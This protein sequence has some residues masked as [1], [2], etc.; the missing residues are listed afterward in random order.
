MPKSESWKLAA[1]NYF[2]RLYIQ[3]F[4]ERFAIYRDENND[5]E[6]D[7]VDESV[8]S[9]NSEVQFSPLIIQDSLLSC[10]Q[11]DSFDD[12]EEEDNNNL[13]DAYEDQDEK[14][15]HEIAT[16]SAKSM[17]SNVRS[18]DNNGFNSH[19]RTSRMLKSI[20][21][22]IAA[23]K[24]KSDDSFRLEW[25]HIPN[26]VEEVRTFFN[27]H[28]TTTWIA[29][30]SDIAMS[31]QPMDSDRIV[32]TA[33]NTWVPS[34]TKIAGKVDIMNDCPKTNWFN[35]VCNSQSRRI[36]WDTY[37]CQCINIRKIDVHRQ[38]RIDNRHEKRKANINNEIGSSSGQKVQRTEPKSFFATVEETKADLNKKI[39]VAI[40]DNRMFQ[41]QLLDN[42]TDLKNLLG[43]FA[44]SQNRYMAMFALQMS[45]GGSSSNSSNE[46]VSMNS[47]KEVVVRI[48]K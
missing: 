21:F 41:Q 4:T 32:S 19:D 24:T 29:A 34:I 38:K 31:I 9:D 22:K 39:D 2:L 35:D 11:S 40:N 28:R 23:D 48:N 42:F 7:G 33:T 30:K 12:M 20:F 36:E 16:S 6:D 27:H 25:G 43:R 8:L 14:D 3:H 44:E 10:E 5:N 18:H 13:H 37:Y 1:Q 26:L 47:T 46:I 45:G 17:P 15:D